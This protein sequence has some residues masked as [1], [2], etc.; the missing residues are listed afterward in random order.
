MM[1]F[2][3]A[4]PV[5]TIFC[6][7]VINTSNQCKHIWERILDTQWLSSLWT[8]RGEFR[9]CDPLQSCLMRATTVPD[10]HI[11]VYVYMPTCV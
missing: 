3:Y 10:A 2:F 6:A 9:I 8:E 1:C 4:L 11:N 5:N 7:S